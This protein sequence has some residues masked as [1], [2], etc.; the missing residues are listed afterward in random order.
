[1]NSDDRTKM[2]TLT[3]SKSEVIGIG[4]GVIGGL[5]YVTRRGAELL[6]I[7]Q[8]QQC[9]TEDYVNL[10]DFLF[11]SIEKIQFKELMSTLQ[12]TGDNSTLLKLR[13][14]EFVWAEVIQ[15]PALMIDTL[16][17]FESALRGNGLKP[18]SKELSI[19]TLNS[20]LHDQKL[21]TEA[22]FELTSVY[23]GDSGCNNGMIMAI[24]ELEG[25][26]EFK[27]VDTGLG[28]SDDD[29]VDDEELLCSEK[30]RRRHDSISS[31]ADAYDEHEKV[32]FE[33]M[34]MYQEIDNTEDEGVETNNG[35]YRVDRRHSDAQS[36]THTN[37]SDTT[38]TDSATTDSAYSS[39]DGKSINNFR[40]TPMNCF[41]HVA[42]KDDSGS[43]CGT[44]DTE[45]WSGSGSDDSNKLSGTQYTDTE[46]EMNFEDVFEEYEEDP[47]K[48]V[49]NSLKRIRISPV[50]GDNISIQCP[51]ALLQSPKLP[52]SEVS[53][54]VQRSLLDRRTE[55]VLT[56]TEEK[57]EGDDE[58][59][60]VGS[61]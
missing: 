27:R 53:G 9:S 61:I 19:A 54:R 25:F 24:C 60:F 42:T 7:I 41:E 57:E 14:G 17:K 44:A 30:N 11:L 55:P 6:G 31:N 22:V 13:S 47:V 51:K 29:T 15:T 33:G 32:E 36:S 43:R 58:G 59:W 5:N 56:V 4:V 26:T 48:N 28:L 1:M 23:V 45:Y 49:S 16:E 2:L 46:E 37:T 21:T 39:N 40:T 18:T 52:V 50:N 3:D 12:E 35:V 38:N 10:Q 34:S 8:L 20:L